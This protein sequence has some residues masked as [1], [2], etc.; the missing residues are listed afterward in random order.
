M[1]TAL[2]LKS[3]IELLAEEANKEQITGCDIALNWK[4]IRCFE[5][6]EEHGLIC[7]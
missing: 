1:L 2:V 5:A 3:H 6:E 7:I 4:I